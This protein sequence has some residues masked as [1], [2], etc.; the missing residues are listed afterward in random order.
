MGLTQCP[1]LFPSP[2]YKIQYLFRCTSLHLVSSLKPSC[3]LPARCSISHGITGCLFRNYLV[4]LGSP[5]WN[6]FSSFDHFSV[7]FM[8][9]SILGNDKKS[10]GTFLFPLCGKRKL[11]GHSRTLSRFSRLHFLLYWCLITLAWQEMGEK[12]PNN[13]S[14]SHIPP[15]KRRHWSVDGLLA[16][17][18]HQLSGMWSREGGCSWIQSCSSDI[19]T[20]I[21]FHCFPR[22]QRT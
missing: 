7:M 14:T 8:S 4:S 1:G 5:P 21:S 19:H 10:L 20:T 18:P 9:L 17:G 12:M 22:S 2:T 11:G 3:L 16:L 6:V 15:S 13:C